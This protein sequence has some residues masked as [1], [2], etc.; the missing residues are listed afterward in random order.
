MNFITNV[1]HLLQWIILAYFF[2]INFLYLL[3][4]VLSLVGLSRHRQLSTYIL[5]KEMLHLPSLKPI[6]IIVPA[7]NE[8]E[9]I[10]ENIHSLLALEYPN[11]EVVVVN[12]GSTD[13]TLERLITYF[14]LKKTFR[15]FR[16]VIDTAPIRGIYIS[17]SYPK[18]VVVDKV[19]GQKADA[20]NAGLNVAR[21]PLFCA[22][23]S[24]SLLDKYAL[25]KIV[26]PFLEEPAK[27]VAAGGII[28]LSNGCRIEYGQV[29]EVGFPRNLLAQ[30]Q[31]IEYLR[32]FL[33]GRTGLSML[34]SLLIISG[35]FGLFQK[36]M[37]LDIQGYRR[38]TVGE[39]MDLV[40]R[41]QKHLL[42]KK[43]PY[44][45]RF[46]PDPICWTEAPEKIKTL[47]RQRNRWHRGLIESIS[48]NRQMILNPRYGS[49]GFFAMPYY[50]IFEMMGPF[51]EF[52]GYILFLF[53]LFKGLINSQ[54]ALLFFTIALIFGIV[55]SLFSILLEEYSA[56]R[57]PRFQHILGLMVASFLE[58]FIFRQY[59]TLVR[60]KAFF[61][62]L[63]GKKEWGKMKRKGFS[64]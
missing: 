17:H 18:L 58:N 14:N 9:T 23:D 1:Y 31:T 61:D 3:F 62:F 47:T 64:R 34:K 52:A 21:F 46:V 24:D 27:M 53:F 12:D 30:F 45:I 48:Y 5:Y 56:C 26:R 19:N 59:L 13:K 2:T 7:F 60:V 40:I 16:K 33:G 41:M 51:I 10:V 11:Y 25:L 15:V 29:K 57:Y 28:R 35:A 63:M 49:I 37:V 22:I 4:T 36:K 43:R 54:F 38:E 44:Q 55:I 6:S 50:V 42:E 32:A 20:L 8:E 39:D